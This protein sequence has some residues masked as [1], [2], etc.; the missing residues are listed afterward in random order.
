M[1]HMAL[2]GIHIRLSEEDAKWL[3]QRADELMT[4]RSQVVRLA[5]RALR[6]D[7][8]KPPLPGVTVR[9]HTGQLSSRKADY[10]GGQR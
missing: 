6:E 10:L 3:D 9:E 4:N 1:S 5:I 8:L 7:G 2:R